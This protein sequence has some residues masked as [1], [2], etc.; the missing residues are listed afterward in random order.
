MI[1]SILISIFA[2][3]FLI[4]CIIFIIAPSAAD[5]K[6]N[7]VVRKQTHI[8]DHAK[9]LHRT[10][11][12]ADL[13]ADSLLWNRD[14]LVRNER[15]HVDIPR[16]IEGNVALQAFTIVT[17]VPR[18]LNINR[19]KDDSD[20]ITLLAVL[21]CWPP[22]TWGSLCQRA[23]YQTEKLKQFEEKSNGKFIIIKTRDDLKSY[24]ERRKTDPSCTAGMLGIEGAH[25]IDGNLENID[26]LYDH[27]VRMMAPTHFFDNDLGSSAHGISHGGLTEKGKELIRRMQA[28]SMIVDLAHASEGVINDAL[29]ISTKPLVVSHTGVK[30]TCNNNRN[31]SDAQIRGIAKTGGII[32]IGYW[33]EAVCGD[34]AQAIAKAIRYASKVAGI[35]HVG[36]GSDFDGT[37]TVPFDSSELVVLTQ[38]LIDEGFSDEEI[39]KIM[40]ENALRVLIQGLPNRSLPPQ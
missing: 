10:L 31:L 9:A 33:H 3:L 32:G 19:N 4:T 26:V 21:S 24:L 2:V 35:D 22:S 12:I 7:A 11:M 25:A 20:D 28:K 38:A 18:E 39:R 13:H 27:G 14:L 23:I 36:L 30:G 29:E 5:K 1:R 16:L 15:G 34:S 8:S 37:V 6:M 17:K 40:G